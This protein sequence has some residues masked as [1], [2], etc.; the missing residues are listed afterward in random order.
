MKTCAFYSVIFDPKKG[1]KNNNNMLQM[2]LLSIKTLK[3][4]NP[5]L[6][7]KVYSNLKREDYIQFNHTVKRGCKN[8]L[9]IHKH[10][11]YGN[12]LEYDSVIYLDPDTIISRNIDYMFEKYSMGISLYENKIE[13]DKFPTDPKY[14]SALNTGVMVMN[15]QTVNSIYKNIDDYRKIV[16]EYS[17]KDGKEI[18]R[19]EEFGFEK[20]LNKYNIQYQLMDPLDSDLAIYESNIFKQLDEYRKST[21]LHYFSS[22]HWD[23]IKQIFY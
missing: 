13:H 16:S 8:W 9:T 17:D 19:A 20:Y 23:V 10:D 4:H 18:Y 6:E 21:I 22:C 1:E 3:Q 12:L 5:N 7:I 14:F 11:H 2:L 15:K